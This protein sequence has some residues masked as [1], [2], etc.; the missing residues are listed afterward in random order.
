M[1]GQ[2]R[3]HGGQ[4]L[5]GALVG[6]GDR[7][8]FGGNRFQK[9]VGRRRAGAA[10]VAGDQTTSNSR[11]RARARH[12]RTQL[13][14]THR[15]GHHRAH[16]QHRQPQPVGELDRDRRGSRWSARSA[17]GP[18]SHP[19]HATR[20][21][22]TRTATSLRRWPAA[23]W[24]I[25]RACIA[26]SSSAG[27]TPNPLTPPAASG[28]RTSANTSSPRTHVAVNPWNAGP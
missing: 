21:P 23:W 11:S 25:M 19:R 20:R 9:L 5:V 12:R 17:R 3:L 22:A 26:A 27:C 1:L 2:P 14:L 13:L 16:R 7:I 8:L 10:D 4:R 28:S 6:R 18:R 24:A 15:A